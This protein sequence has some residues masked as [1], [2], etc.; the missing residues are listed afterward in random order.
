MKIEEFKK[1]LR[2]SLE[3]ICRDNN[4][5]FDNNKQRG[6]A[7]ENWCFN[8]FCER[9]PAA[10]NNPDECIIRGDDAGIDVFLAAD[11]VAALEALKLFVPIR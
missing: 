11:I 9:Y 10:E 6:M 4:W 3:Q 1:T 5:S 8:L 2:S 7:F